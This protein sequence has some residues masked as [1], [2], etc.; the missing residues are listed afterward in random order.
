VGRIRSESGSGRGAI[1]P[2]VARIPDLSYLGRVKRD[3]GKDWL[4][5]L[6]ATERRARSLPPEHPS[7]RHLRDIKVLLGILVALA[8][9]AG[10]IV[11]QV[12]LD[13][14]NREV[15]AASK[16]MERAGQYLDDSG[17]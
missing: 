3:I 8:L 1:T 11:L 5:E 9:I 12:E 2:G 6:Q 15:D 7:E 10:F 16:Q 17:R 13:K 4:A 14:K